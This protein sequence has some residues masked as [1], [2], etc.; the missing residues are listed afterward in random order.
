MY[1]WTRSWIGLRATH[2][3]IRKGRL[4]D[5]FYDDDSYAFA[6]Q[7]QQETLIIAINRA[8]QEK[9]LTV[10]AGSV[11]VRDG[12]KLSVLIGTTGGSRVANGQVELKVPPRTAVAFKA[13]SERE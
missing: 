5:L 12:S 2:S 8:A 13:V 1:D 9:K 7:D 3:S 10:P 6:R 11:G 4:I